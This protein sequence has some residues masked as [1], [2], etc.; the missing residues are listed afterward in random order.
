MKPEHHASPIIAHASRGKHLLGVARAALYV[1]LIAALSGVLATRKVVAELSEHTLRLGDDMG[2]WSS[3]IGPST[4][5]TLNGQ[6]LLLGSRTVDLSIEQVL[7]RFSALC[8]QDAGDPLASLGSTHDAKPASTLE[9]Q[10]LEP[11]LV[12]RHSTGNEGAATCFVGAGRGG[13]SALAGRLQELVRT[14]DLSALGALRYLRVRKLAQGSHVVV[15]WNRGPL[16]IDA[17]FPEHGDAPGED[18]ALGARPP[19]AVRMFSAATRGSEHGVNMYRSRRPSEHALEQ[20]G[21]SLQARGFAPRDAVP[22]SAALRKLGRIYV[23]D[24]ETLLVRA[25][26]EDEGSL[27]SVV[28]LAAGQANGGGAVP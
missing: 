24:G 14:R 12:L 18:F 1:A 27:V 13:I 5:V 7:A 21:R 2:E 4:Q 6:Q 8:M 28:Q 17:M 15:V 20:Y 26:P 16:R 11:L 3:L 25:E 9:E 23:K 22:G 19:D 10:L